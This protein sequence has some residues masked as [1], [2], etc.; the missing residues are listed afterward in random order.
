[1]LSHCFT[2]YIKVSF[3]NGSS[4]DPL[5]PVASKHDLVRYLHIHENE[6]LDEDL[7]A[8]W[9]RQASEL[10]GEELF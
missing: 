2:K 6:E 10:P 5:P 9:L 1:M 3:H 8:S 4:L 7:L